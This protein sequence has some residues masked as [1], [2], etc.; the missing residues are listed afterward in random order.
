MNFMD[1]FEVEKFSET[2]KAPTPI[3][4]DES[5]RLQT[6]QMN[7]VCDFVQNDKQ[8]FIRYAPRQIGK[9]T[10]LT[11]LSLYLAFRGK[12]V[13]FVGT[14]TVIDM[15]RFVVNKNLKL[16]TVE[17]NT[18]HIIRFRNGGSINFCGDLS[19]ASYVRGCSFDYIFVDEFSIFRSPSEEWFS[20][21]YISL[22]KDGKMF[23]LSSVGF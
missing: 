23:L 19:V 5:M 6:D 16:H 18:K 7:L 13:I 21:L 12:K 3:N 1:I 2:F 15:V 10:L 11:I 14:P 9:T 17:E 8:I 4:L 20:N 22:N